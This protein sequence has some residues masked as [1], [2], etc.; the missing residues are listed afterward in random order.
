MSDI[1]SWVLKWK[2]LRRL[3]AI[4]ASSELD[5]LGSRE[6]LLENLLALAINSSVRSEDSEKQEHLFPIVNLI[7]S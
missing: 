3:S 1:L 2:G 4:F 5:W 6:G 7:G